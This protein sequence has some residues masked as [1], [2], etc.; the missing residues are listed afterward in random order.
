MATGMQMALK[1]LGIDAASIE[2]KVTEVAAAVQGVLGEIKSRL[3]AIQSDVTAT[4]NGVD[5]VSTKIDLLRGSLLDEPPTYLPG[6]VTA[7]YAKHL[8]E[9]GEAAS[10]LNGALEQ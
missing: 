7:D 9:T 5:L 1:A 2:A 4:K 3:D 6:G 8:I 10:A